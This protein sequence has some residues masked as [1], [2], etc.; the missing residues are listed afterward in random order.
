MRY[1]IFLTLLLVNFNAFAIE[2]VKIVNERKIIFDPSPYNVQANYKKA[3]MRALVT[4]GW[5]ITAITDQKISGRLKNDSYSPVEIDITDSASIV[6]QF[7]DPNKS[8]RTNHL[9][10]LKRDML[11]S[12]L[13]CAFNK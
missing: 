2:D 5:T 3:A 10:N 8:A 13:S 6:I 1:L 12:L 4:R 7:V 11:D 9:L